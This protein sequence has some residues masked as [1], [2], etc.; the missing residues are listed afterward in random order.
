MRAIAVQKVVKEAVVKTFSLQEY[1]LKEEKS[2]HKN[3]FYNGQIIPMPSNK[4]RHNEIATNIT[5]AIKVAVR[6]LPKVFRVFNS[7][8]KIYIEAENV[9]VYPDAV[10]VC[11][12]PQ[13]WNGRE[14]LIVN[15]LLVVEVL[16]KST[17]KYDR[18]DKFMLYQ[19]MPS[20]KEYL[21][22]EQNKPCVESWFKS[23]DTNWNKLLTEDLTQ[24]IHLRS[25]NVTIP[26]ADIYEHILFPKIK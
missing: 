16:S 2:L 6:P 25:L 17:F 14:D 19:L 21:L 13:F 26:L 15:P 20:F 23:S 10:V 5:S 9:S 4:A 8:Q 18:G 3:E 12:A 1:L 11:E 7:D 24:S 22:I